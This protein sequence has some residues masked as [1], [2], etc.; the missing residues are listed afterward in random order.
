MDV[1][2]HVRVVSFQTRPKPGPDLAQSLLGWG[3]GGEVMVMD[4]GGH[5]V[6]LVL[7]VS[8]PGVRERLGRQ[9]AFLCRGEEC[10][11][12]GEF[13]QSTDVILKCNRLSYSS[14]T[15]WS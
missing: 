3:L 11:V 13:G 15:D 9:Q 6:S 4:E 14:H 7:M 8:T 12:T 1:D 5:S 2:I 10:G